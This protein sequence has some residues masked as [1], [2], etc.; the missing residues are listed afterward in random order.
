MTDAAVQVVGA[1]TL[2]ATLHSAADDL[3]DFSG[4]GTQTTALIASRARTE[5]PRRTGRLASSITTR[6][7][8]LEA[9]V[10]SGLA[11]SNRTHW[12]YARYGQ[13][14]QP[15]LVRPAHQL[16]PVWTRFYSAE[17]DRIVHT[18]RGA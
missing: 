18:V 11:Y 10:S 6:T 14:A 13:A 8:A 4:P 9:E 5:V 2:A 15:F 16:I 1:D 12:G 7:K 17:V 3:D